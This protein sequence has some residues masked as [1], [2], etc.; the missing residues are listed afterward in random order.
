MSLLTRLS[1]LRH[2]R[3]FGVHS[4]LAYELIT[5]VLTDRPP[6]YA[7]SAIDNMFD[8]RRSRR[9]ARKLL[10][11]VAHFE[12]ATACVPP[13]YRPVVTLADRRTQLTDSAED[14]GLTLTEED[15][16][17]VFIVGQP[18]PGCGPLVL[19]NDTDTRIVVYRD[20]LTPATIL[21]TL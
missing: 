7:D 3:G 14:A 12:P 10:R 9:T 6:Y 2:G 20:G 18:A 16:S 19:D 5:S 8:D 1:A 21:T 13:V 15:G 11:L 4:P 17:T